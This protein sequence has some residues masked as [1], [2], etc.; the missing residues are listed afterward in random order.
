MY[1]IYESF[2]GNPKN[3]HHKSKKKKISGGDGCSLNWLWQSL[4]DVSEII[5]L[6]TSN[7]YSTVQQ[8]I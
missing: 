7:L 6:Y 2:R 3:P 5:M 8:Y 1:V 4:N